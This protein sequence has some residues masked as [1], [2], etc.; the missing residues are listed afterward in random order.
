MIIHTFSS[1]AYRSFSPQSQKGEVD[2][3]ATLVGYKEDMLKEAGVKEM[4]EPFPQPVDEE[5]EDYDDE[6]EETYEM[7]NHAMSETVELFLTIDH[8]ITRARRE[9]AKS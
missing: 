1:S 8:E 6:D 9:G 3:R 5:D 2:I 7:H 4:P